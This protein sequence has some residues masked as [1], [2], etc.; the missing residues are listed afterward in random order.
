[1]ILPKVKFS[2]HHVWHLFVIRCESRDVLQK[3]LLDK[4]IQTLIHYPIPPHKQEAYKIYNSLNLPITE[5]IHEEVLSLPISPVMTSE[6]IN[7][8]IDKLNDF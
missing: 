6:Q 3:Y 5:K 2:E 8:V 1:I 7:Y 4:G